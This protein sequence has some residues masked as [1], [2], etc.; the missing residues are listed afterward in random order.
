M[1]MLLLL[2]VVGCSEY[3]IQAEQPDN[4]GA[5]PDT[6][7]PDTI[8]VLEGPENFGEPEDTAEP[9]NDEE[10]PPAAAPVYAHTGTQLFEVEP[11]T[12]ERTLIG[13]FSSKDG[14]ELSSF[15]DIAIDLEGKMYG[16]TFDA[17]YRIDPST[18]AVTA[19]C[20][21]DAGM[22]ALTFTSDNELIAG[23]DD[24]V[25]IINIT[26]CRVTELVTE[27]NYETSGDLV[28]LPDGYLYWTVDSGDLDGLVKV[29]PLT[30]QT[31]WIGD[32]GYSKIFGLGYNEGE[33]LG[34][35]SWGETITISPTTAEASVLTKDDEMS[36]YGATT[37]PVEW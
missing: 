6:A 31:T 15:V 29:D 28:G 12:G 2:A 7:A 10:P 4:Q 13:V 21:P 18:A 23:G 5:E 1:R 34:F 25:N 33:L 32:T 17:L 35:N 19:I 3:G 11:A 20:S 9:A 27:G 36:W 37:N 22:V 8:P 16:G 26:N 24:G 30:G 14:A